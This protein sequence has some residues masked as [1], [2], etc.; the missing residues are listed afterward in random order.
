VKTVRVRICVVVDEAGRFTSA[1]WS[2]GS[3]ASVKDVALDSFE[4]NGRERI[5]WVEADVPLP[6]AEATVA[7]EVA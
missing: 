3:D 1:G 2:E 4:P 6:E 5:T 7:G